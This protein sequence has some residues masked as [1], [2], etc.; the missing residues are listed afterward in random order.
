MAQQLR[1]LAALPEDL[2]SIPNIQMV[3]HRSYNSGSR[4]S[5]TLFWALQ[6]LGTHKVHRYVFRQNPHTLHI[7]KND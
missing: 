4:A 6:T 3:A 5:K 1:A 7:N 2:S